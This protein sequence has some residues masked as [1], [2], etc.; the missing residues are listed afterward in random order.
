MVDRLAELDVSALF[1]IGGDGSMRGALDIA[2]EVRRRG[3]D[4]A[5]IGVPKTI[6]N[7]LK[8]MDRSFGFQTAYAKA[9]EAIEGAHREAQGAPNGI[10]LV[11]VMGRHAG[12]IACAAT[13]ASGN[14]NFTLI[15]EVPFTL[16]GPGG[17]LEVLHRRLE[18]RHHAVIVVAEGAG[19][20]HFAGPRRARRVGQPEA[21][22]DRRLSRLAH[23]RALRRAGLRDQPE[24][25]R[26]ELHHPQRAC[27][28]RRRRLLRDA[29]HERRARGMCGKT[30]MMIG[31]WR[32]TLVHVPINLAI[33]E[34]NHVD[35]TGTLWLSVLGTTGQ[36][37][38]FQDLPSP[39]GA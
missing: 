20:E 19:Q 9:V 34:R 3:L 22:R 8:W 15:P 18:R 13:V 31:S 27:E 16:D 25:H 30:E 37:L 39:T 21:A 1:I 28:R 26:S 14:V 10:G 24:V 7:D 6:D 29:R 12:F 5:I 36:P 35:P 11:K 38:A 17:L 2:A 32:H 4:I 23:P 33:A